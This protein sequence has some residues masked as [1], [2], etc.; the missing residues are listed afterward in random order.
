MATGS[1][2]ALFVG[3]DGFGLLLGETSSVPTGYPLLLVPVG[4]F[5]PTLKPSLMKSVHPYSRWCVKISGRPSDDGAASLE[6]QS[7][8]DKLDHCL[9]QYSE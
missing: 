9:Q 3:V 6:G 2:P 8:S 7:Y 4:L 5:I 1:C